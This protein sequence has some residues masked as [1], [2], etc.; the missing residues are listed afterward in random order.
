MTLST[1]ARVAQPEPRL[2]PLWTNLKVAVQRLSPSNLTAW[3]DLQRRMGETPQIQV[4]QAC[5]VI[6]NTIQRCNCCQRCFNKLLSKGSEYLCKY[7][8]LKYEAVNL[9][10][11]LARGKLSQWLM[12]IPH[13]YDDNIVSVLCIICII[14][15]VILCD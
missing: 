9:A 11:H 1:Q 4:G 14:F 13:T 5:S 2:K 8:Q 3:G 7:F 6:P 10:W 12:N 15:C